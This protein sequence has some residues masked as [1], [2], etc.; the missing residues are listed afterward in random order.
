VLQAALPAVTAALRT[1]P[2]NRLKVSAFAISFWDP[3][4]WGEAGPVLTGDLND[5]LK[6]LRQHF[7]VEA[8]KKHGTELMLVDDYI[9]PTH[10]QLAATHPRSFQ[11]AVAHCGFVATAVRPA[12]RQSN[13][14]VTLFE[15]AR[16]Q[17][18]AEG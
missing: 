1:S 12:P 2:I 7:R 3:P 13:P 6:Q 17:G 16:Q 5:R 18:A 9:F 8:Q 14:R 15:L 10:P 11:V 4:A